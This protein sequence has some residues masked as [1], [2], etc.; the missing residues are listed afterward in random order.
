MYMI[1]VYGKNELNN[2]QSKI[3]MDVC[4]FQNCRKRS[5]GG[6][7]RDKDK[8]EVRKEGGGEK[9]EVGREGERK[10]GKT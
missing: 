1:D 10:E 2:W 4:P 5:G 3:S 9:E 7:E 6:R 8:E